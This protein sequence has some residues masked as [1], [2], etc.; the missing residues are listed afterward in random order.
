MII[1]SSFKTP[2]PPSIYL[3][4]PVPR[5]KVVCSK[6]ISFVAGMLRIRSGVL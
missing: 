2:F 4:Y 3:I 5:K 6:I 1:L